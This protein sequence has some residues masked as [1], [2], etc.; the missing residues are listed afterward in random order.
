MPKWATP[1]RQAHLVNLF[2]RSGGFCIFGEKPCTNPT[3]HH[4]DPFIEGL[5]ADWKADDRAERSALWQV[6]LKAL[7]GLAERGAVRG[8]FNAIGRDVFFSQQ[9]Q[10]YLDGLGISGLTF[11]PFAKVRLASSYMCL[12]IDIGE[13]VKATSK[14]RRRKAIRYGKPL[15]QEVRVEIDRI[16]RQAVRHYLR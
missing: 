1:S 2:L 11:R 13:A 3:L 15:P 6:E 7:H 9:P 4:Y 12:H 8:Q 5:I 16:C 14:A 10:Y